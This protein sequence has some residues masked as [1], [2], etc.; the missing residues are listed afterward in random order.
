[1]KRQASRRT[2]CAARRVASE[3]A[4]G[5]EV[6]RR[7]RHRRA[8]ARCL[9]E[10]GH[11][12]HRAALPGGGAPGVR[13]PRCGPATCWW[14]APIS[15]S[16]RRANR[17]RRR[18]C[19]WACARSI[20][21]SYS[22]LYLSQ[23]VQSRPA[24][25]DLCTGRRTARRRDWWIWTCR[26]CRSP[27]GRRRGTAV[28]TDPGLPARHGGR[29][30]FAEPV[31]PADEAHAVNMTVSPASITVALGE[32]LPWLW[33]AAPEL[34]DAVQLRAKRLWT[35][36][37]SCAWSGLQ[38][39]TCR[40]WLSLQGVSERGSVPLPGSAV[41]LTPAAAAASLAMGACWDEACEGLALAHGRPGVPIVAA[42]WSQ[43]GL[44][45]PSWQRLW[46]A[47]AVGYEVGARLGA[48]LRIRP[49]HHV[50]GMWS[51]FGAAAA[52]AYLHGLDCQ[53][54]L[55]VLE[56]CA[57]QL[58]Y[59][60]YQP[61]AQGA[62]ARNLYLGHSSWL[63]LQAVQAV[64]AG[65][66]A[67]VGA[68][69]TFAAAG[70]GQWRG[71]D[72]RA[73]RALVE[74]GQLLEAFCGSAPPALRCPGSHRP[75]C[76]TAGPPGDFRT[77]TGRVSGG[78]GVLRQPRSADRDR[79]AVQPELRPCVRRWYLATCRPKNIDRRDSGTRKCGASNSCWRYN[80]MPRPSPVFNAAHICRRW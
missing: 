32:V 1:M 13:C 74:S 55:R 19:I 20:A 43:L 36:T 5:L 41:R 62:N 8:G 68:I 61:I 15:A 21:P 66:T 3:P 46:R 22:G 63:A 14:P 54:A 48:R 56:I 57:V 30:R 78:N 24:A 51:S 50:D 38:D 37:V 76:T 77:A 7:H 25:A 49:G 53:A 60:L 64:R 11:R 70:A 65:I 71:R 34:P 72:G 44:I 52:L 4:Q 45:Q 59:S 10:A 58:P 39:A 23:C 9:H 16:V 31:A 79:G 47:T 42:L 40:D 29:R 73:G 69:D 12:R 80:P 18:W 67:P 27:V 6:R 35:D 28:R 33:Q 17:P 75:A 26:R 2:E